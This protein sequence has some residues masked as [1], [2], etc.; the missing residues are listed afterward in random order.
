MK[1]SVIIPV[2][3]EMQTLDAIL[4]KVR[5]VPVQKELILVDDFSKDGSRE[6]LQAMAQQNDP[7]I[8]VLFHEKNKGKGAAIRTGIEAATGDL[9]IIQ[10]ADLEYDPNDYIKLI[11][12]MDQQ[13]ADV[14]YGS[15]FL[16]EC[17]NMSASHLFGNKLLTFITNL[18]FGAKLTDMETCYKLVK[19]PLFKSFTIKTD[20]FNFEPEITSKLLKKKIK[21]VEIPI[22]YNAREF[23]QGKKI[24]WKDG[25]SAVWALVKFRFVD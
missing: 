25:F 6:K 15:R 22:T 12:A 21:I 2:Y 14:V 16:G 11:A 13:H 4:K 20:R 5:D 18:L 3:N 8:K 17:K 10:D 1:L 9:T 19:T 24:S 7:A 23:D